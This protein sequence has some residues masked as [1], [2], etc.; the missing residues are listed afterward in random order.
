[1]PGMIEAHQNPKVSLVSIF[2]FSLKTR[3]FP[4]VDHL[5]Y[6]TDSLKTGQAVLE[7]RHLVSE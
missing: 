4:F 5:Y 3:Y 6:I 1:M 2:L 7:R